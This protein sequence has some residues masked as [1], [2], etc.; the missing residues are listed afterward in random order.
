MNL[1]YL[2]LAFLA[3]V[4]VIWLKRPLFM[5][6]GAGI[7]AAVILFGVPASVWWGI[8]KRGAFSR[9]TLTVLGA[10][11]TI[12]Y[13]QR[14]L[15]SKNRLIQAEAALSDLTGSRRLNIMMTPFIIG[16][17]PSAGAV[18]LAAPIVDKIAG[19]ELDVKERTFVASFYRHISE[20]FLPTYAAII[21]ALKLSGH[22]PLQFVVYMLPMVAVLFLLGYLLYVRKLTKG[23]DAAV[24]GAQKRAAFLRLIRSL[25]T[26]LTV[27]VLIMIIKAPVYLVVAAVILVNAVAER[28]TFRQLG[29]FAV[30]AFETKL[31]LNTI[32]IMVFKE[33]LLYAGALTSLTDSFAGL[34]IP[35]DML[36]LLIMFIGV[37]LAGAQAMIAV[38]FPL[39]FLEGGS[40]MPLLVLLMCVGYIAMQIS[41][42]H[43]CLSVVTEH[44]KTT[45]LDLF[46]KTLPV[47]VMFIVVSLVYYFLLRLVM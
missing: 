2:L 37:V 43:I 6:M 23:A 29:S 24:Q 3:I 39:A 31:M 19:D 42:T 13:L 22:E 34:P 30:K 38:L 47:L 27:V 9:D 28:F 10:F 4:A 46:R 1:L 20:A 11:Y 14:M 8:L 45:L 44:Y 12:T 7:V 33:V 25:W 40:N 32:F 35:P 5:A 41:P 36:F 17:L 26:I 15:E 21:L 18:L 16:M